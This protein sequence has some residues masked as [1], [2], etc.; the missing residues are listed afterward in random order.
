MR[1]PLIALA[2]LLVISPGC[3]VA[4]SNLLRVCADPNNLPFSDASEDGFENRLAEL[5]AKEMGKIVSYTWWAQRRGFIRHTLK[6]GQCDLVMGLPSDF[7]LAETTRPYYRSTYV[8]VSRADS[9]I[10]VDSLKDPR[11]RKLKIGVHLFG[12]DG[13]NAPPAHALGEQGI[14]GNVIGYTIYGDYRDSAP[15]ARLI[16]AVEKGDVALAAVW[17]PLAG[18]AALHSTIPLRIV[19][20]KGTESFAPLKFTFD[21]A[22]GVRKGD[23]AL[24]ERLDEIIARRRPEIDALL[25]RYGVP[26]VGAERGE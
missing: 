6:A 11:L 10:D 13:M 21:I 20:M 12:D 3:A 22:M 1:A 9:A 17:G 4:Q 7:E 2:A 26:T 16:E 19:P 5:V 15:P 18:Y 24:R 14:V 23:H 25:A 8:F